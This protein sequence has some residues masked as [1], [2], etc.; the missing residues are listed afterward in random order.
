[1][2]AAASDVTF[3]AGTELSLRVSLSKKFLRRFDE[4]PTRR[5]GEGSY[6]K[7][8]FK[9]VSE[10]GRCWQLILV[11]AEGGKKVWDVSQVLC[12]ERHWRSSNPVALSLPH[13]SRRDHSSWSSDSSKL[14][15]AKQKRGG[16]HAHATRVNVQHNAPHLAEKLP[17]GWDKGVEIIKQI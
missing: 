17:T 6:G 8:C 2:L 7:S 9:A 12:G 13:G 15:K 10:R 11:R 4:E 14:C 3:A 1:M 16:N 5:W